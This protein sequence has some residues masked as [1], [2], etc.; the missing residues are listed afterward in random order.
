[1]TVGMDEIAQ[2]PAQNGFGRI[3]GARSAAG[4]VMAASATADPGRFFQSH[5]VQHV[6]QDRH[7]QPPFLGLT[8]T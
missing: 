6:L 8:N 7:E 3:E 5:A 2:M 4:R 1:M